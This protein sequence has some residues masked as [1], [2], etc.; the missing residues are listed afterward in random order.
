[1]SIL[2]ITKSQLLH[3][4][5][6]LFAAHS[7]ESSVGTL[8]LDDEDRRILYTVM[9]KHF[10]KKY[11]DGIREEKMALDAPDKNQL[12]IVDE[13]DKKLDEDTVS[14]KRKKRDTLADGNG[15]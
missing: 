4:N 7:I 6:T 11:R 2:P 10:N 14:S 9:M 5:K 1:M 12:D 13:I 3:I 8:H 15:T